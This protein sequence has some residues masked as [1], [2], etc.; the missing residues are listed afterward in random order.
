MSCFELMFLVVV[1]VVAMAQD[2]GKCPVTKE[3]LTMDDIVA[4]KTNK[5][6]LRWNAEKI[7]VKWQASAACGV[8]L[9]M[10]CTSN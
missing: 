6:R 2:H 10:F 7:I 9:P 5:V 4:V 3:E 8:D 1:M